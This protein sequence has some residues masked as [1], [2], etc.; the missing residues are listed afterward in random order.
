LL[1]AATGSIDSIDILGRRTPA[2]DHSR[3]AGSGE[4]RRRMALD[5]DSAPRYT[6]AVILCSIRLS[7]RWLALA[8]ALCLL[9]CPPAT[10]PGSGAVGE[11]AP[12]ITGK[13]LDG[14]YAALSD[15]AGDVVLVNLWAT[16]CGPC[17]A[18]LPALEKLHR[19]YRERGF[20]VLAVSVDSE[21]GE[22]AVASMVR[23]VKITFP[24][25]LDPSARSSTAYEASGYPTSVLVGRDGKV[26]WR[27]S[28]ALTASDAEV[29]AAIS[30]AIAEP[31]PSS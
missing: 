19:S 25:L 17:R 10:P 22:T 26:R 13:S 9:A 28:G 11:I 7:P 29:L 12:R 15:F 18:E 27:R 3:C 24:V 1:C 21:R 20:T 16:W 6:R 4:R 2:A 5:G 14:D 23:D 31:K 30:S 8:G